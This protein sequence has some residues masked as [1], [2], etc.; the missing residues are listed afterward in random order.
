MFWNSIF[1][2]QVVSI[3][4]LSPAAIS[5]P[6]IFGFRDEDP[7][8]ADDHISQIFPGLT[9]DCTEAGAGELA[10]W[11]WGVGGSPA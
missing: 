6:V 9:Q 4:G 10:E 1:L 11:K 3:F 5:E 7:I 2:V 8:L